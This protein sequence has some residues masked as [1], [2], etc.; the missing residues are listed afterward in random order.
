VSKTDQEV[1]VTA[2]AAVSEE[3][4][5]ALLAEKQ[6]IEQQLES[7]LDQ[8]K[9][10]E[11]K[12]KTRGKDKESDSVADFPTTAVKLAAELGFTTPQLAIQGHNSNRQTGDAP[13]WH[14][15]EG[16][17]FGGYS[18]YDNNIPARVKSAVDRALAGLVDNNYGALSKFHELNQ[19]V[20]GIAFVPHES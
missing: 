9:Q 20:V 6:D 16:L 2:P 5:S 17:S 18:G 13:V 19:I 7:A 15:V 10:L 8:V 11:T 1:T 14:Y 4:F 3:E 12:L